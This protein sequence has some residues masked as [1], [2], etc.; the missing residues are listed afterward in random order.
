MGGSIQH[1]PCGAAAEAGGALNCTRLGMQRATPL[2]STN[3]SLPS[4][5]AF[6]IPRR[7]NQHRT[8]LIFP[9][10]CFEQGQKILPSLKSFFS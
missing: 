4:A 2:C 3:Q 1:R 7:M 6:N 8:A 10:I 5:F 9:A